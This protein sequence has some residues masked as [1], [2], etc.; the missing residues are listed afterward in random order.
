MNAGRNVGGR[1]AAGDGRDEFGGVGNGRFRRGRLFDDDAAAEDWPGVMLS[2]EG[3]L[4][5]NG[6]AGGRGAGYVGGGGVRWALL[7]GRSRTGVRGGG[8]IYHGKEK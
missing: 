1:G 7:C 6:L 2:M 5:L 3:F 4:K 8:G